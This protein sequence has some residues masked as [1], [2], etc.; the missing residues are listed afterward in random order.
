MAARF[1]SAQD[2]RTG[3]TTYTCSWVIPKTTEAWHDPWIEFI[4]REEIG[5]AEL[6][7]EE[8]R[9]ALKCWDN[10]VKEEDKMRV[11]IFYVAVTGG[12]SKKEVVACDEK[13]A[14]LELGRLGVRVQ[15]IVKLSEVLVLTEEQMELYQKR[16]R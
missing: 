14:Y 12:I 2:Y 10:L 1:I 9:S 13:D 4:E 3:Y 7:E 11:W 8:L 16:P 6:T 5:T 15:D